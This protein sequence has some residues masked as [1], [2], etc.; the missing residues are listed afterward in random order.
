MVCQYER[1]AGYA[2]FADETLH[3]VILGD[4]A[5]VN[6]RRHQAVGV[7]TGLRVTG[8]ERSQDVVLAPQPSVDPGFDLA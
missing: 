2:Y 4:R 3:F 6:E 5:P 1:V 8:F 7:S